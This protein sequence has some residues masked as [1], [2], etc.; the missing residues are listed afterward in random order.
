MSLQLTPDVPE[1]DALLRASAGVL[2]Y[3]DTPRIAAGVHA[4]LEDGEESLRD[5]LT[6]MLRPR[7]VQVATAAPIQTLPLSS[8]PPP[9]LV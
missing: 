5:R 8:R 3:P 2:V 7:F 4:R 6:A 9:P 1:M